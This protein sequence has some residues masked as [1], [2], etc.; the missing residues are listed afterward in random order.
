V[1]FVSTE[2]NKVI[3]TAFLE[4][5]KKASKTLLLSLNIVMT[6]FDCKLSSRM[7]AWYITHASAEKIVVSAGNLCFNASPS[8]GE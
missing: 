3:G 7:R 6:Q 2:G 5:E 8:S 4:E 1:K